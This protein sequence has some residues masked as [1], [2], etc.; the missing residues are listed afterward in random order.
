MVYSDLSDVIGTIAETTDFLP[1][2]A[3]HDKIEIHVSGIRLLGDDTTARRFLLSLHNQIGDERHSERYPQDLTSGGGA[4]FRAPQHRGNFA[5]EIS[6][7]KGN[8]ARRTIVGYPLIAGPI[9]C[10]RFGRAESHGPTSY[11]VS[12]TLSLNPTRF[13]RHNFST[14]SSAG[15]RSGQALSHPD[16]RLLTR[17]IGRNHA[18]EHILDDNDNCILEGRILRFC[19]GSIYEAWAESYIRDATAHVLRRMEHA[20]HLS[21]SRYID[22]D[23]EFNLRKIETY[24]ERTSPSPL[25]YVRDL[26]DR[27]LARSS[28]IRIAGYAATTSYRR[29][30][31]SLSIDVPL[32]KGVSLKIYAKTNLRVRFEVAHN[33]VEAT[34]HLGTRHTTTSLDELMRWTNDTIDAAR[35]SIM[36]LL[37]V[38]QVQESSAYQAEA[39]ISFFQLLYQA[40][41][42]A[43]DLRRLA[44]ILI[45]VGGIAGG[46][47]SITE[48][49]E[50][51][52]RQGVLV[53]AGRGVRSLAPMYASSLLK[54]RNTHN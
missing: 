45:E 16:W 36:N 15:I 48:A 24:W 6:F 51:L 11:A 33:F 34:N 42:A 38:L 18:G 37:P 50:H 14:G 47:E 54:L 2:E 25:G 29:E 17:A 39:V 53:P 22:R 19:R 5:G 49:V 7:R 30:R 21:Q 27:F 28:R 20:A 4:F 40:P 35:G 10:S 52:V 23:I 3:K 12:A 41:G 32:R 46:D 1:N 9:K 31:N 13:V 44:Q 26:A 8:I 43:D